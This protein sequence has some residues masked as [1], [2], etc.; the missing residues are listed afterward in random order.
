M[1][2]YNVHIYWLYIYTGIIHIYLYLSI[3]LSLSLFMYVCIYIYIYIYHYKIFVECVLLDMDI[4]LMQV[5][6][7][8]YFS[9]EISIAGF[10]IQSNQRSGWWKYWC[11][12]IIWYHIHNGH[13][14]NYCYKK[15]A[16]F[17]SHCWKCRKDHLLLLMKSCRRTV[18]L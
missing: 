8:L 11:K 18:L 12:S 6:F 1:Y 2:I 10:S 14:E 3:Y 9:G 16:Y 15:W 5:L 13:P 4:D 7:F 17:Y